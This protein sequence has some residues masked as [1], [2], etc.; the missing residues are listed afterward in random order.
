MS[1]AETVPCSK[2]WST[3]FDRELRRVID[4]IRLGDLDDALAMAESVAGRA[5]PLGDDYARGRALTFMAEVAHLQG[6]LGAAR[7][8]GD[9]AERLLRG[10]GLW[11]GVSRVCRILADLART[12]GNGSEAWRHLTDAV[13][14]AEMMATSG[15]EADVRA[16]ALFECHVLAAGLLRDENRVDEG[17]E[18]LRQA[19]L[20]AVEM[21]DPMLLGDLSLVRGRFE[22]LIDPPRGLEMIRRAA[23]IYTHNRLTL[24]TAVAREAEADC[25]LSIGDLAGARDAYAGALALSADSNAPERTERLAAVLA[26]LEERLAAARSARQGGVA[27]GAASGPALAAALAHPTIAS[28]VDPEARFSEFCAHLTSVIVRDLGVAAAAAVVHDLGG[29]AHQVIASEPAAAASER[30]ASPSGAVSLPID[31]DLRL[32]L[33]LQGATADAASVVE[34]LRRLAALRVSDQVA[35]DLGREP[36]V[37]RAEALRHGMVIASLEMQAV[38]NQVIKAAQADC[39]VLIMGESGTGKERVARAAHELSRRKSEPFIVTNCAAFPSELVESK[40]FGHRKGAFTGATSDS[41]GLFRAADRGSLFLDEIGELPLALQPKLLRALDVGEIEPLGA[42]SPVKVGARVLAA[43][44]RDLELEASEGRFREDLFHR[45]AVVTIAIPPLR[46]RPADIIPLARHFVR[47]ICEESGVGHVVEIH[48]S[49]EVLLREHDWPGNVRQLHNVLLRTLLLNDFRLIRAQDVRPWVA[50][51]G[52][53]Q[54]P[55]LL[56]PKPTRLDDVVADAARRAIVDA[57]AAAGGSRS[58]ACRR[59]GITRG[60]FYR[61]AK[62]V[63]L[64]L[65]STAKDES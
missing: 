20:L 18:R 8:A 42:T 54:R 21:S 44:N 49:A 23:R 39:T 63:G 3:R 47:Q 29:G 64:D 32:S 60:R 41:P 34:P 36:L 13:A 61:L 55:E 58:E 22:W 17:L 12:E 62:E 16:R 57:L 40:L 1:R 38:L 37:T 19:D 56:A 7:S 65:S 48:P 35:F 33:E 24:R 30:L 4:A 59:L 27:R 43:T 10:I 45:L 53:P 31:A 52:H 14:A 15:P 51:R 6:R 11:G 9:D 50:R 2:V 46:S 28:L 25:L 26:G 5:A